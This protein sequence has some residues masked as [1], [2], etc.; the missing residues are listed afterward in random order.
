MALSALRLATINQV[1]EVLIHI[2]FNTKNALN[3][4]K[5]ADPDETS[6][7]VASHLGLRYM[8]KLI[9]LIIL[10]YINTLTTSS[11]LRT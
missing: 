1:K 10:F 7:F 5:S 4:A 8:H 11:Q 6:P 3:M 9:L 2:R